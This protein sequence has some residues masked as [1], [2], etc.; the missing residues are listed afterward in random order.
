MALEGRLVEVEGDGKGTKN[1][2]IGFAIFVIWQL[3]SFP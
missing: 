1:L 3:A 2:S